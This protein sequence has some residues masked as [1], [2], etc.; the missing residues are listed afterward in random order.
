VNKNTKY[1]PHITWGM[2]KHNPRCYVLNRRAG[3]LKPL[4]MLPPQQMIEYQIAV[5]H[6]TAQM[7]ELANGRV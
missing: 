2:H 6:L 7:R 1:K 5:G 3:I 4:W